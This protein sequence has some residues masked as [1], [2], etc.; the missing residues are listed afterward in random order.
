MLSHA[1]IDKQELVEEEPYSYDQAKKVKWYY[2]ILLNRPIKVILAVILLGILVPILLYQFV[3][4]SSGDWP[5]LD[6][7]STG[8]CLLNRFARIPCGNGSMEQSNCHSQCCYDLNTNFCFHRFPSRFSYILNHQW[9][10]NTILVPRIP[11]VPFKNLPSIPGIKIA[12]DEISSTHLSFTFYDQTIMDLTGSKLE[13]KSYDY[14]LSAQELS[15][16]VNSDQGIIFS[17][18][19]GPLIASDGIWEIAFRLTNETMYGL[20]EIPL[21]EG[22][23]KVIYNYDGGLSSVPLI[24]AKSNGSYHGLLVDVKEPS[25]MIVGGENQMLLRS[26]TSRGL[27]FHL[28][29]GPEPS[30]VMKD[31]RKLLGSNSQ[32]E[33]WM[34]GAHVCNEIESS[35]SEAF[36]HLTNFTAAATQAQVPYDSHCG[37]SPIVLEN[38]CGAQTYIDEG[39]RLVKNANKRF[40][41][42][43]SPYIRYT[44]E[45]TSNSETTTETT[46]SRIEETT[47]PGEEDEE[48]A[49]LAVDFEE[50]MIRNHAGKIYKGMVEKHSVIYPTY[51]NVSHEFIKNWWQY[52]E[53]LDG[54]FLEN[55]WPL[56]EAVKNH[57]YA[58]S[59]LPYYNQHF[60]TAFD[61]TLLWNTSLPDGTMYFHEHNAFS[62]HFVDAVKLAS[63]GIPTWTASQWQNGD[64]MIHRQ[65]VETSWSNLN[66]ELIQAALGGISGHW[67][68]SS[69]ICGDTFNYNSTTQ[70]ELCLKWYLASTFMP[71]IK[72][73]SKGV[74]RHPLSF[75][76]IERT[77][78]INSLRNRLT[79]MPYFFTVL[80]EGPLL[81]PM[82]Y[83]FPK[84]ERLAIL[85]SQYSVGE[86]L[87]MVPN[88]LPNQGHVH[89]R[90]PPGTW[91]ELWGGS[92]LVGEEG[93][94]VTMTDTTRDI[95]TF[96]RAGSII[97]M[98]K[99]PSVTAELTRQQAFISLTIALDHQIL[100]ETDHENITTSIDSYQ[101]SGKLYITE[102]LTIS[103]EA[104]EERLLATSLG[105]DFDPLCGLTAVSNRFVTE[106][107]IF[108]LPSERNNYDN[109]RLISSVIILCN[110][111]TQPEI[112]FVYT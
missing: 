73:H 20:G 75:E 104:N 47:L 106:L 62:N 13:N 98:Q 16:T 48:C 35:P 95:L 76:G 107:K 49:D 55:T 56:D 2:Y 41:P 4:V 5:P 15:V 1:N 43:L 101:A 89:V 82:F 36:Q 70:R 109:Y 38:K 24:F 96:I 81:R 29:V 46:E 68:W 39:G 33:Y 7:Y 66:K 11:T 86:D 71:M 77:V 72:I 52:N 59:A 105:D 8:T 74:E 87:L 110:L 23:S 67:L 53:T 80:Q 32:L 85:T 99:N 63:D 17:T 21:L 18:A 45:N 19:R 34:L 6:G 69:P 28:F 61:K 30:D 3:Y 14:T 10:E 102:N 12:V 51:R 58:Y 27:K 78:A 60:E 44:E 108:G 92:Q 100:N 9:S 84:S 93:E 26:L 25:E 22:T 97:V 94:A 88:L 103:F 83:Q 90:V 42:H 31:V 54:I 79:L 112:T 57:S 50:Y 91:F 40:T 64:V 111:Q 37:T 65:N